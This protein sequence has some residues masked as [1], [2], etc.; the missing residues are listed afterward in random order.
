MVHVTSTCNC[1]EIFCDLFLFVV[2]DDVFLFGAVVWSP[3]VLL[4]P[5]AFNVFTL[6]YNIYI[7]KEHQHA[8]HLCELVFGLETSLLRCVPTSFILAL[9][10][11]FF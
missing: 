1:C 11:F 7:K 4:K 3:M 9:H 2:V 6:I 10:L 8:I 5:W